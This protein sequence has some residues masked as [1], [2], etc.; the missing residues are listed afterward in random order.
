MAR[1]VDQ[2]GARAGPRPALSPS[3]MVPRHRSVSTLLLVVWGCGKTELSHSEQPSS[4]EWPVI[5]NVGGERLYSGEA[6]EG[7][8]LSDGSLVIAHRG[9]QEILWLDREGRLTQRVG[10]RG[11]GPG[12]FRG[13]NS[14]L[15]TRDDTVMAYD[16]RLSRLTVFSGSG[17]L[18]RTHRIPSDVG[19]S[20]K[21]VGLV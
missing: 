2:C 18:V 7:A 17:T 1:Q 6:N 5:L 8:L 12:E 4:G 13:L 14:I 16:G 3:S 20:E 19:L 9:D 10:R 15:V 11:S 21:L